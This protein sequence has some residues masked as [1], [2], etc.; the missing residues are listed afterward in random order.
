MPIHLENRRVL[1]ADDE[2]LIADTLADLRVLLFSGKACTADLLS[3]ARWRGHEFE[4]LSKPVHPKDLLAKIQ[5]ENETA[6]T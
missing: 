6:A 1:V 4:P 5:G 3:E 2:I